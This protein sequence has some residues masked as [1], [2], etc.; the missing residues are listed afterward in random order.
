MDDSVGRDGL[1]DRAN[2][3]QG[4]ETSHLLTQDPALETTPTPPSK[5]IQGIK[6]TTTNPSLAKADSGETRA[7]PLLHS[8][9]PSQALESTWL[10]NLYASPMFLDSVGPESLHLPHRNGCA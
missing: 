5:S 1:S 3:I 4:D 10:I 2:C 9:S 7:C 8:R 6:V